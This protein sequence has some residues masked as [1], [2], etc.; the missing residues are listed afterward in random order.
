MKG[1]T[2]KNSLVARKKKIFERL[3]YYGIDEPILNT[4]ILNHSQ[5]NHIEPDKAAER[6]LILLGIATS[7]YNFDESEKVMDWLKKENL[8]KSV[9]DKEKEFFR[10]PHPEDEQKQTLSWRFEGAYVLAWALGK[11]SA[12]ADPSNECTEEQITEFLKQVPSVGTSTEQFFID[13]QFRP[14][15]VIL[16]ESLFHEIATEYFR[17][18]LIQDKENT[19]QVHAKATLERHQALSWLRNTGEESGWD[20]ISTTS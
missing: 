19:S 8:W 10:N 7:A 17:N 4:E 5:Y 13:L 14:F 15:T 11:V 16:D 20:A 3:K 1:E 2:I 18:I 9:S 6:L 12:A